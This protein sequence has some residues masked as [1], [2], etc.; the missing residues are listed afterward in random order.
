VI[1]HVEVRNWQSLRHVVLDL[2]R[3][4]VI[5]GASSSGKS[6]FVRA[7]KALASNVRGTSAIT[8]GT[9]SAAI[10][11]TTGD[12]TVTL[13]H[14][15]GAWAYR[16]AG[17]EGEQTYTKLGGQVPAAVTAVLGI[18]P[19]PSGGTS[20]SFA[21]QFDPPYLLADSGAAV[22][23]V[24]G[25]LT[26]V[27]TIFAA[28]RE[29]NRRQKHA[30]ATLRTKE[31]ELA[32]FRS[33][34]GQFADLPQRLT[35]LRRAETAVAHAQH[36]QQQ[37]DRLHGHVEGIE[38]A[39]AIL[40]TATGALEQTAIT[41]LDLT[42]VTEAHQRYLAFTALLR[43]WQAAHAWQQRAQQAADAAERAERDAVRALHETLV[44]AGQCPVCGQQVKDENHATGQ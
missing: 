6:A 31:A 1:E 19:V 13:E 4:T 16:I 14:V 20:I 44:A 39:R 21:G 8:K 30:S 38:R 32:T 34:L 7:L 9:T 12:A 28:V 17:G 36:L 43:E 5:V 27:D 37:A 15:G 25:E 10:S 2:G 40:A 26:N 29:A 24:F 41:R 42:A 11:A 23:R 33:R 18:E 22:A 35:A 3:F